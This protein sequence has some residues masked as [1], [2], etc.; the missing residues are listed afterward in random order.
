VRPLLTQPRQVHLVRRIRRRL[1]RQ[2][3]AVEGPIE[4]EVL[5]DRVRAAWDIGSSKQVVQVS[6]RN[7]LKLLA[8]KKLVVCSETT[9]DLPGR[10]L[11]AARTPSADFD[12]KKVSQV[13][14]IERRVALLGVLSESPGLQRTELARET[15]RFFGW[16]RLGPDIRAA[17]EADI[18]RLIAAGLITTGPSGLVPVESAAG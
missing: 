4:E 13:P 15:A 8:R 17:F 18:E 5:I 6:V 11:A 16:L 7:A 14:P 9:W 2:I 3:I 12:R 1:A 10:Q